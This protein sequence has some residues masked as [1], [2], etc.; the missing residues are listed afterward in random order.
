MKR[1]FQKQ[2]S[3]NVLSI[4][5]MP[6]QTKVHFKFLQLFVVTG[7]VVLYTR[8]LDESGSLAVFKLFLATGITRVY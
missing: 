2:F 6:V 8:G 3:K 7:Y 1:V 4:R 5:Q